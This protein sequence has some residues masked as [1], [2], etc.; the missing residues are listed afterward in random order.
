MGLGT[1][2]LR[3]LLT[4]A[5]L[6]ACGSERTALPADTGVTTTTGPVGTS[7]PEDPLAPTDP[8]VPSELVLQ[9]RTGGTPFEDGFRIVPEFTLY[10]DGLVVHG[11]AEVAVHPPAALPP[12]F[13]GR[14]PDREVKMAIAAARKAGLADAPDL[15]SPQISHQA[16]TRFVFVDRGRT[17]MVAA[18]ALGENGQELSAGQRLRRRRLQ[19]LQRRMEE[20]AAGADEPY[21]A[22]AVSVLVRPAAEPGMAPRGGAGAEAEWP[23][24]DLAN[25]E[26]A[27]PG[28]PCLGFVGAEADRVLAAASKAR[29]N[30]LWRSGGSTW[31]LSFRP[32]LPGNVPCRPQP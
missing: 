23:L 25:A 18:Y 1:A 16:T 22:E 7:S 11:G 15:G 5:T 20:L 19:D 27:Q 3:I 17:H 6:G 32:E 26:R 10:A 2:C 29:S 28:G 24:G 12:L 9:I 21:R 30:T 14:V 31:L 13:S 4:V 8:P